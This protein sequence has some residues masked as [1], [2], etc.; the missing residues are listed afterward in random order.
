MQLTTEQSE[1]EAEKAAATDAEAMGKLMEETLE[2]E[3]QEPPPPEAEQ[4]E[5]PP[6]ETKPA[7]PPAAEAKPAE[8]K[9]PELDEF[10]QDLD[11]AKYDLPAGATRQ[12]KEVNKAVRQTAREEHSRWRNAEQ[13]RL[14]AERKAKELEEKMG[15]AAKDREEL[16]RLRPIVE[17]FA[18]ERDPQLNARFNTEMQKIDHRIL[19][20][21]RNHGLSKE[22][23]KYIMEHGG[24]AQFSKDSVS[25]VDAEPEYD[26]GPEIK[27]SH[28]Q[29]WQERVMKQL[30]EDHQRPIKLAFDDE[31]RLKEWR[32]G[33]LR[34]RLSNR[35]QY[36]KNLEEES[37]RSEETFKTE[38]KNA[39]D[40]QLKDLGDLVNE[41]TIPADAS[42]E[43]KQ[44]LESYNRVVRDAKAKFDS[45]FVDRSP[46]ALVKK[47]LGGLFLD[48]IKTLVALK[49]AEI[50]QERSAREALQKKWD[51]TRSAANT[52]NRQSVQQQAKPLESQQPFERNDG[53]RME[54]MMQQI[55]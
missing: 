16:D 14:E 34:S 8:D 35:E 4:H 38:C 22:T 23:A 50:A 6:A 43:L 9:P 45:Y 28:K 53:R 41:K 18:I 52:L 5:Q 25:K 32:D 17:T 1:A 2:A 46:A 44:Q 31:L 27:M 55:P 49:D 21:L 19:T 15:T 37:K 42:P 20:N 40:N 29:F 33:E 24:P 11:S 54:Q 36:F 48:N 26:G 51:A 39:L 10:E 12:A 30:N 3:H 47:S 13:A 7:E